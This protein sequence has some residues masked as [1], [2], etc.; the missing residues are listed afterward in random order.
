MQ[1]QCS[2]VL[3]C[4]WFGRT[5]YLFIYLFF[6]FFFFFWG[7]GGYKMGNDECF[8]F[9]TNLLTTAQV[10]RPRNA[11]SIVGAHPSPGA[12]HSSRPLRQPRQPSVASRPDTWL[13]CPPMVWRNDRG[14]SEEGHSQRLCHRG[15]CSGGRLLRHPQGPVRILFLIAG[16]WCLHGTEPDYPCSQVV[17][18]TSCEKFGTAFYVLQVRNGG[19]H[20]QKVDDR[21]LE[22]V[23]IFRQLHSHL[24]GQCRSHQRQ[25]FLDMPQILDNQ[26]AIQ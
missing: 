26:R 8:H 21:L 13:L 7:G 12:A 1:S 24:E 16:P 9:N 3:L 5:I 20:I 14:W 2:A 10:F 4:F 6:F 17:C 25:M 23:G 11:K 18:S 19:F 22:A 15:G